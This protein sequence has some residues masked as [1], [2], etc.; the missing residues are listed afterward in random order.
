M[1]L[2][3]S[4][5]LNCVEAPCNAKQSENL[6]K[7]TLSW[8]SCS[9]YER[10]IRKQQGTVANSWNP[11]YLGGRD[12]KDHSPGQPEQKYQTLFQK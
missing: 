4:W 5:V 12:G 10:K 6:H 11:N 1:S 7:V 9:Y 8:K 2:T 3:Q